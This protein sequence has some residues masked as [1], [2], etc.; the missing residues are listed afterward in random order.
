MVGLGCNRR[1]A[2]LGV[3][4]TARAQPHVSEPN[5]VHT[6]GLTAKLSLKAYL[7]GGLGAQGSC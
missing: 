6:H 5:L 1:T 4:C 2:A 3:D 7:G